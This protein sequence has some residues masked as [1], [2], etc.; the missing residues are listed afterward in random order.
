M[1]E[2]ITVKKDE[3]KTKDEVET[4]NDLLDKARAYTWK[5]AQ[6]IIQVFQNHPRYSHYQLP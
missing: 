5:E 1:S 2:E 6:L 4:D 3:G